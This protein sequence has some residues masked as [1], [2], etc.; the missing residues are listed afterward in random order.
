MECERIQE[1]VLESLCEPRPAAIQAAIESHLLTC[2]ACAAFAARQARLDAELRVALAAPTL[3]PR[4]RAK[5]RLRIRHE[6]RSVWSDSLLDVVHFASCGIVTIA[7]LI[8]L[9]FNPATVLAI[10]VGATM[11]SHAVLTAAHG[12]LEAVDD[13]GL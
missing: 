13:R 2:P 8:V 12:S 10:A 3:N 11:V 1:E 6:P 4:L 9:P 7:S 5:V